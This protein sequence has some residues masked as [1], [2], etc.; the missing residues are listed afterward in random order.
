MENFYYLQLFNQSKNS[1]PAELFEIHT[2]LCLQKLR[3]TFISADCCKY[4]STIAQK[5]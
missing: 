2:V 5:L 1:I 3:R 4:N